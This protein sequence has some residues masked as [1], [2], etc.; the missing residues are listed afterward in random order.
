[1][2]YLVIVESP[3]KAITLGKFLGGEY[4][5][6]AT[7][8]HVRDLPE[9]EMGIDIEH[10]FKPEYVLISKKKDGLAEIKKL[11]KESDQIFLATDPDREGEAIAWH[12]SELLVKS[13]E[14]KSQ[15]VKRKKDSGRLKR[16]SFH[17]ITQTAIHQ[18]IEN[19][20]EID[21]PLVDA[22]QARRV[23]DRLVGYKLSPLLWKKVKRGLSAGRVQ[24]VALR[25]VAERE[26]EITAFKPQ[27]YW[28]VLV[29][30]SA[31]QEAHNF[32]AKLV[33]S[34]DKKL[35]VG[36]REESAP[37]VSDLEVADYKVLSVDS[38]EAI[39]TP[40]APFTTSTLQ[41]AAANRFGWSAKRTMQL[42]QELYERGLI[43]YHRTD[44]TNLSE[45]SIGMVRDYLKQEYPP[46]YLPETPRFYKTKSKVAQEAHEAIRPTGLGKFTENKYPFSNRD[47]ERLYDLIFKRFVACQ[48]GV[49]RSEETTVDVE[50]RASGGQY[51]L[52]ATGSRLIFD[53]W[54]KLYNTQED[55]EDEENRSLLP[56]L[57]Q[58]QSLQKISVKPAQKFTQPPARYNEASLI[59]K[60]EE[61][62]IGRPSTYAPILSTI[63][64][65]LYVEKVDPKT[66]LVPGKALKP[67][68]LGLAVNDF[69]VANFADVVDYQFTARMEESLD[70]IANGEKQW[71]PVVRE[72][73]GPFSKELTKAGE[74]ERI[75]VELEETG[76]KCPECSEGTLVIR[77]GR[78]GK[79]IS[80]SRFPEC[81]YRR[82]Y[83][84]KLEG[85]KCPLDG[86]DV[87][88]RKTRKGKVFYGCVNWPGCKWASWTKPRGTESVA[89]GEL[90]PPKEAQTT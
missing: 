37:I 38:R 68:L 63:Q 51:L 17:E 34:N 12:I 71:V 59:K 40:P 66:G 45:M 16:I 41:Q 13:S 52:Q 27:E 20:R 70:E 21:I 54:M 48:M 30:L 39:K 81:K 4:V 53:G 79:F 57:V 5:V 89:S 22:Q 8:G 15:K 72:F 69:L 42:A 61:L 28:E 9:K 11:A 49:A 33:K 18:A 90:P 85:A 29:E 25:I 73:Y 56:P 32:W 55:L 80:C 23:L 50:A 88:L 65:R 77:L 7:M 24:S 84:P 75:K 83:V 2:E 60:L 31:G 44:S 3:T 82:Q 36:T 19:P 76:E 35:A 86:G 87:V 47:G 78:F 64:E 58:G 26:R 10:D 1:M 46:E 14:V 43:T 67:T 74:S 62:G 6:K